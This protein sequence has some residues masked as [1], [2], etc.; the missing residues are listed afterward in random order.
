MSSSNFVAELTT[1]YGKL[2]E[3]TVNYD[4]VIYTGKDKEFYAHS[5]ILSAR[6]DIFRVMFS[7]VWAEKK[8]G[9]F[10]LYKPNISPEIFTIILSIFI[11]EFL[12]QDPVDI[13]E[14]S[15]QHRMFMGLRYICLENICKNPKALF[16]SKNFVKLKSYL[17]KIVLKRN[18][19][20]MDDVEVW[21]KLLLWC[22]VQQN[23]RNDPN[24]QIFIA[25]SMFIKV[26][27][28]KN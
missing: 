14:I 16:D 2:L 17:L 11:T 8:K 27:Y 4:V 1:V 7:N 24:L 28:R 5:S 22:F 6:S 21:E 12:L 10:V 13:L 20:N 19:L 25:R 15:Y 23:I 26:Y 9:K 3:E 18:D